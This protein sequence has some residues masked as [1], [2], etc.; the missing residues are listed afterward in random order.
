MPSKW[1]AKAESPSSLD[2][3]EASSRYASKTTEPTALVR[4]LA[5]AVSGSTTFDAVS[6]CCS[7]VKHALIFG[8]DPT[9][10]R[11]SR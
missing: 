3:M 11:K 8:D 10:V 9:V 6:T 1:R 7:T 5:A 4:L 2:A